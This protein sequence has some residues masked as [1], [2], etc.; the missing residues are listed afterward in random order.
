MSDQ[1]MPNTNGP[2]FRGLFI[3]INRYQSPDVD[4]LASAVR[5]AK[6]MHALFSDNLGGDCKLI[7]DSDA[8]SQRFRDELL[9]LQK[10][11]AQDDV[12]VVMFSGHGSD[13]HQLATFEADLNN[14]PS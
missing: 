8:T 11:S 3:G 14:L 10:D 5:D 12:V 13:T 4:N 7:T 9:Q 1:A 2:R 6:G